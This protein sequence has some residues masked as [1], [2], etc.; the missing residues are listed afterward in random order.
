MQRAM[1]T[2]RDHVVKVQMASDFACRGKNKLKCKMLH[3]WRVKTAISTDFNL[4]CLEFTEKKESKLL[5]AAFVEW[6][7]AR[8]HRI[9]L[10]T[11]LQRACNAWKLK[12]RD[13][14]YHSGPVVK[15]RCIALWSLHV[16]QER[17]TKRIE[18]TCTHL[19]SG[20]DRRIMAGALTAWAQSTKERRKSRQDV[21]TRI[22]D[23]RTQHLQQQ[24]LCLW[25]SR[26]T[27]L[28]LT[29]ASLHSAW[30][31]DHPLR[32]AI[33][34]WVESLS[35]VRR[36]RRLESISK[37]LATTKHLHNSTTIPASQYA[38]CSPMTNLHD[39]D[40]TACH[41]ESPNAIS[42]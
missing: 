3:F 10:R 26:S 32:R 21:Y 24:A 12:L 28:S 30:T 35:K 11:V 33:H 38:W 34:A 8:H 41:R 39:K 2:W 36:R 25:H 18:Q 5:T 23:R 17:E 14:E 4:R 40:A 9:L 37:Q 20:R 15:S 6:K 7:R 1:S 19:S 22:H 29:L 42:V 16:H 13:E 27:R 31:Y